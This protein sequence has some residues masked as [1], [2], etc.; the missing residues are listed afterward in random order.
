[1]H[2]WW[3]HSL[4][5]QARVQTNMGNL[6]Y[7]PPK[8]AAGAASRAEVP[9][10]CSH[11]SS[12]YE[13][14]SAAFPSE[15]PHPRDR[16]HHTRLLQA[17]STVPNPNTFHQEVA[18]RKSLWQSATKTL[19]KTVTKTLNDTRA[20]M[21]TFP[22]LIT[23]LHPLHLMPVTSASVERANSALKFVKTYWRTRW[24]RAGWMP[25][26]S[27]SCTRT[28]S[29]RWARWW[30]LL[31]GGNHENCF[32]LA[33]NPMADVWRTFSTTENTGHDTIGLQSYTGLCPVDNM[34]MY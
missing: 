26:C 20:S 24:A 29:C 28:Y 7:C 16:E 1:M 25:F 14:S 6:T 19:P 27:C 5:W 33:A 9:V 12:C 34:Y 13:S 22:T 30:T 18:M 32:D 3:R 23:S 2:I 15:K 31:W 10:H 11:Q 21:R 17:W 4:S 8:P